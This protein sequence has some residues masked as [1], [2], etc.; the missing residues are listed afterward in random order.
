MPS[1]KVRIGEPIDKALR[2]LKKKLDKEGIMKAAK[3]HRFHD[4]KSV[5][6]RLKSKAATK[7]TKTAARRG[8]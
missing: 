5:K 1:V 3:A 2:A 6:K 4:K 7:R 8:F